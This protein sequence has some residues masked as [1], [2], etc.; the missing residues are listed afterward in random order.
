MFTV[1]RFGRCVKITFNSAELTRF[2]RKVEGVVEVR[3]NA[4]SLGYFHSGLMIAHAV[5]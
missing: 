4:V 1:I 5:L 2:V 3:H